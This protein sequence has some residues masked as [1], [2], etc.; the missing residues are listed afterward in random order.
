MSDKIVYLEINGVS[1]PIGRI[2][3]VED[4]GAC[5]SYAKEY[6]ESS[7]PKAISVSLPLA[8]RDF[9][10]E[11]TKVFFDGLLPEGF[12]RREVAR[13][14]HADEADYLTILSGLGKECIGGVRIL[15][16]NEPSPE[17][18]YEELTME[19][20]KSLAEEGVAKSVEIVTNTHLS[21]TG[22]SGKVGLYQDAN[23]GKWYLPYGDAPST[24]IIKQ[25]HVRL[26]DIVINE[27]MMMLTAAE[28]GLDTVE[29]NILNCGGGADHE[30][31]FATKRY[32]RCFPKKKV[33]IGG[34]ARP[35]RLHQED[36][37][38]AMG[39]PSAEKYE[40][41]DQGYLKRM[42]DIVRQNSSD[43]LRDQ[44]ELW[45][46][47][48]FN[49]LIGNTDA[50]IKNF[51]LLYDEGM[52]RIRLAPAYDMISTVVYSESTRNMSFYIG[53]EVNLDRITDSCFEKASAEAGIGRALAMSR[54]EK[55]RSEIGPA[56]KKAR[57]RL[58]S[59]GFPGADRVYKQVIQGL[60]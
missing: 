29:S 44:I 35:N 31:L 47:I 1:T 60:H 48:V 13:Q 19:Q 52:N 49:F 42:F 33:K 3:D 32:D 30:I 17:A 50:H 45:D 6:L 39:I 24:H 57:G 15:Q 40:T 41:T 5:F 46:R 23:S 27:Q 28:L 53:G 51:S 34:L 12:T 25:S 54:V 14:L 38:Q 8:R 4:E 56:L 26:E 59:S 36:F 10:A 21:L 43:P 2:H 7:N 9:S 22:A 55:M 11:E 20:I 37:A 18:A 58:N 16:E